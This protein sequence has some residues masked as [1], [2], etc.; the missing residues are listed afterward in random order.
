MVIFFTSLIQL[1]DINKWRSVTEKIHD[2]QIILSKLWHLIN[3]TEPYNFRE[4]VY[5]MII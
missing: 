2:D 4:K 5:Q 1:L 3:W